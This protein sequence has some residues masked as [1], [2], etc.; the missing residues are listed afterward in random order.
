MLG[1]MAS[2]LFGLYVKGVLPVG[3]LLTKREV[4]KEAEVTAR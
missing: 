4:M 1:G 2:G 3:G